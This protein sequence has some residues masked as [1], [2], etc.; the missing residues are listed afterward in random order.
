MTGYYN[1]SDSVRLVNSSSPPSKINIVL[2]AN[3]TYTVDKPFVIKDANI[4]MYA[5]PGAYY[6]KTPTGLSAGYADGTTGSTGRGYLNIDIYGDT[7]NVVVGNYIGIK[8]EYFG[9]TSAASATGYQTL[10]GI[11]RVNDVDYTNDIIRV[12]ARILSGSGVTGARMFTGSLS[13]PSISQFDVYTTSVEFQNCNGFMVEPTG[14]LSLG[15]PNSAGVSGSPFI[16][17]RTGSLTAGQYAKGVY[18]SGGKA[19]LGNSMGLMSWPT[20]GAA[21]Y[22]ANGG[23][24]NGVGIIGSNNGTFSYAEAG[25]SI[26]LSYPIVSRNDT[27]IILDSGAKMTINGFNVDGNNRRF[28]SVNNG[29]TSL[30]LNSGSL[31]VKDTKPQIIMDAAQT[32]LL[33]SRASFIIQGAS[34]SDGAIIGATGTVGVRGISLNY[35]SSGTIELGS[36]TI[37]SSVTGGSL[38]TL[39][40]K[41]GTITSVYAA[42][43]GVG[44]NLGDKYL[45]TQPPTNG[46]N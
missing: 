23:L 24:I 12:E 20:Y 32:G 29:T 22:A 16:I 36:A 3:S 8:P 10:C 31:I 6:N 9:L 2:S 41:T 25:S 28:L 45:G 1:L 21:L 18:V 34:G 39:T 14:V 40:K 46:S 30:L 5:Q 42:P 15:T 17:I 44:A 43:A 4:S 13:Y 33:A 11:Y 26:M 35:A 37:R 7:N 27:A 38:L 19:F